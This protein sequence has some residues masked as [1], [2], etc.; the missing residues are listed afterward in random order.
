MRA[1]PP[2]SDFSKSSAANSSQFVSPA[3]LLTTST[4]PENVS[5]GGLIG[6]ET[7]N[8]H[9]KLVPSLAFLNSHVHG[10]MQASPS[11]RCTLGHS[12]GRKKK[13]IEDNLDEESLDFEI[14]MEFWYW[15]WKVKYFFTLVSESSG[16]NSKPS[17]LCNLCGKKST[18]DPFR[19]STSAAHQERVANYF[20]EQEEDNLILNAQSQEQ[21]EPPLNLEWPQDLLSDSSSK[22]STPTGGLDVHGKSMLDVLDLLGANSSG[23][24]ESVGSQSDFGGEAFNL[25]LN[26]L[27]GMDDEDL[28]EEDEAE[29]ERVLD[30]ELAEANQQEARDWFPFKK[31]EHA[32]GMLAIGTS[33]NLL[34]RSQY[35]R[36]RI[37]FRICNVKIP[38]W[39]TVRA[40][41][42]R[43][44]KRVGL[45]ISERISPTGTPLFGLNL[46]E[47]IK[48][49]FSNPFVSPHIA[50]LPEDNS[51]SPINSLTGSRKWLEGYKKEIR[52]QMV[53]STIGH[54][55]IYEIYQ[56]F[57]NQLVVPTHFFKKDGKLF[58][59]CL[60]ARVV[61]KDRN[62]NTFM[63][64]I[65]DEPP[66]DSSL[67]HLV[68]I[69]SFWRD[70]DH[71][72][73]NNKGLLKDFCSKEI[74]QSKPNGYVSLPLV[75]PWR[76][77]AKGKVIK[78]TPINLYSDDTSGNV[79]KKYNKHMNVLFS[80]S[81]LPPEILNQEYNVHFLATSNCASAPELLDHVVDEINDLSVEGFEVYDHA[82]GD[83]V[84]V[85]VVVLCYLGD[86]PMHAEICNTTNPA[87]T[88]TA[89]R[90]CDLHVDTMAEKKTE[91]YVRHFVGLDLDSE[92]SGL[93]KRDWDDTR[94]KTKEIWKIAQAPHSKG[95]KKIQSAYERNDG[96]VVQ[97]ICQKLD[98][99]V[100]D[101]L[102]NP[103][104]CLK[105]FNGHLD[106][107]VEILHVVLLGIVKY[108]FRDEMKM[109]GSMKTGTEKYAELSARWRSFNTKGLKIPPIQPNTLIQFSNSPIGKEFRVVLQT[110][111]FVFFKYISPAK[112]HIWIS[113]RLLTSYIFQ[114][115]ISNMATYLTELRSCIDIFLINLIGINARWV[116][117]PKFHMLT[118]LPESIQRY[119]PAPLVGTEPFESFNGVTRK[120][121]VHSNRQSPGHD[122]ADTFNTHQL[123]KIFTSKSAFYDQELDALTT[124]GPELTS[125]LLNNAEIQH[126]LGRNLKV[127]KEHDFIA[128]IEK[129]DFLLMKEHVRIGQV[130]SIW[131]PKDS[132]ASKSLVLMKKCKR[133]G[134]VEF[135]GMREIVISEHEVWMKPKDIE[136]ILNV[137]HNCHEALCSPIHDQHRRVKRRTA[138]TFPNARICHTE[139]N[140]YI[141]NA[142]ALY[143]AESHRKASELECL[144]PTPEEWDE[145]IEKGIA[146]WESEPVKPR[147]KRKQQDV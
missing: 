29:A 7:E 52:P 45:S 115:E 112:R 31:K 128:G 67:L 138:K 100:G 46:Q 53:T 24:D 40:L 83:N 36:I 64:V 88:L 16:P 51:N 87:N 57:S 86:S 17:Y 74:R 111:P 72:V 77:K 75:N 108:L 80:L 50:C 56:L 68:E 131:I 22:D 127:E 11:G 116:N 25:L 104:L 10:T 85:L 146:V 58:S 3:P 65:S 109:I 98:D 94:S 81:G 23:D 134:V 18:T 119:G 123:L 41:K 38:D 110:V 106:T 35:N 20:A 101:H 137:Q 118:H 124:A 43:L 6:Q 8:Y 82:S 126:S 27:D 63:I 47:I 84:L 44:K 99:E 21:L 144:S 121:S 19:H 102:F 54:I 28:D 113:L 1:A 34:S 33:R 42:N 73:F 114:T 26:A 129:D 66:F 143:N 95:L 71:V 117:K 61:P 69:S 96:D 103:M 14:G 15:N 62:R 120:A 91:E 55:Y 92:H 122:I 39:S 105:G 141:L 70:F 5:H 135:Y 59:K 93:S 89:C 12:K 136:C 145:A 140:S 142:A 9:P 30:R 90:M 139:L 147:A 13:A 4:L 76:L 78:H 2:A 37:L 125:H 107:P 32:V 49:D 133:G 79:S 97:E 132:A 130:Q 60:Q 48:Q